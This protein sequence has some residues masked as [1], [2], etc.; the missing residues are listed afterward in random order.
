MAH[1]HKDAKQTYLGCFDNEDEAARK[2]DEA[3]ATLGWPL[4]FPKAEG[5]ARAVKKKAMEG[6]SRRS[7]TKGC[8][9]SRA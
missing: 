5:E 6:I 8:P 7:L 4:N 9:P 3:A 2:Y 1:I